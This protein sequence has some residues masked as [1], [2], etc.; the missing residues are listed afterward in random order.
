MK[1]MVPIVND[2]TNLKKSVLYFFKPISST[3]KLSHFYA[4]HIYKYI[5][6]QTIEVKSH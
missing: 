5:R 3:F 6:I 2:S 4:L 1:N